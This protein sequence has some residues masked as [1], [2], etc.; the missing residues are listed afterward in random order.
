MLLHHTAATYS[1]TP[2]PPCRPLSHSRTTTPKEEGGTVPLTPCLL[3]AAT[4]GWNPLLT[5][6]HKAYPTA[7]GTV[8]ISLVAVLL[9]RALIRLPRTIAGVRTIRVITTT[10][11]VE[12]TAAAAATMTGG[13]RGTMIAITTATTITSPLLLQAT[14]K[15]LTGLTIVGAE[16]REE[17]VGEGKTGM[18]GEAITAAALVDKITTPTIPIGTTSSPP[19]LTLMTGIRTVRIGRGAQGVVGEAMPTREVTDTKKCFYVTC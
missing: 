11:V 19:P 18:A 7:V 6:K 15:V 16:E 4:V 12:E 10:A 9:L 1:N 13:T 3:R 17:E 5:I 2:S 8:A 14:G